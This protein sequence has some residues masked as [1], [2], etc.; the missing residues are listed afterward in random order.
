MVKTTN[1]ERT[2]SVRLLAGLAA[3]ARMSGA[4]RRVLAALLLAQT[5]RGRPFTASRWQVAEATGLGLRTVERALGHLRELG[6]TVQTGE[7][8]ESGRHFMIL[9]GQLAAAGG[10]AGGESAVKVEFRPRSRSGA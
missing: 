8:D 1:D 4:D 3:D 10:E 5:E 9:P 6:H 2:V 7:K